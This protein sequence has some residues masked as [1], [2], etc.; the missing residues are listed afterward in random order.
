MPFDKLLLTICMLFAC[1]SLSLADSKPIMVIELFRH[2][3]RAPYGDSWDINKAWTDR[4]GEL[5]S[6]GMRMHY[7]L[8]KTLAQEY[9]HL[10]ATYDPKQISIFSSDVNRTIMSAYSQLF[11]MFSPGTSSLTEDQGKI[12]VPPGLQ[13]SNVSEFI[14]DNYSLPKGIQPAPVHMVEPISDYSLAPAVS[15][16]NFF[17][18]T[19]DSYTSPAFTEYLNITN[20]TMNL[21]AQIAKHFNLSEPDI[22]AG[23][24]LA[25]M[26]ITN[27]YENI[28]SP[29]NVTYGSK[30]WYDIQFLGDWLIT[31][32]FT[33]PVK[34]LQLMG[35][36]LFARM[37]DL[38]DG[39]LNGTF[40]KSFVL[41]SAHD[42]NVLTMLAVFDTVT[43]DC[44][45]DVYLGKVNSSLC[46][47]PGYSAN[48]IT[49]LYNDTATPY[50]KF[51]YNG[52]YLN[53]CNTS[54]NSC[55][56][57]AYKRLVNK[58]LQNYNLTAWRIEC[59]VSQDT[60]TPPQP[61]PTPDPKP[62][63]NSSNNSALIAVIVVLG[64]IITIELAVLIMI[65][66]KP[67][68]KVSSG[69]NYSSLI[70]A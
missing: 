49:E 47:Y 22:W 43:A 9:S 48:V 58:K 42:V 14:S 19:G 11:G 53:P 44:L 28:P 41:L 17:A 1:C 38:L 68:K 63:D 69:S 24:A 57:E 37:F 16:V 62:D 8:G 10:L 12:A 4:I 15:C 7:L 20:S 6:A 66:R 34:A 31:Y 21:I 61:K 33:G 65:I 54:D 32:V 59:G 23:S 27:H 36:P 26:L 70:M 50:V 60:P 45:R 67:S 3:A 39:K 55:T 51:K 56:L 18:V 25:D 2:G 13:Y 5:T 46:V 35:Y 52:V 30:E 29:F 40:N 64:V